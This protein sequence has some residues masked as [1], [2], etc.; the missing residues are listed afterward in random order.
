MQEAAELS[1]QAWTLREQY[2]GASMQAQ[3]QKEAQTERWQRPRQLDDGMHADA[4]K[5]EAAPIK[6]RTLGMSL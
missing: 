6:S 5:A 1:P 2:P 4:D 3:C